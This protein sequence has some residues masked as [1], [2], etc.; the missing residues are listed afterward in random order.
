LQQK[1]IKVFWTTFS[2]FFLYIICHKLTENKNLDTKEFFLRNQSEAK[3]SKRYNLNSGAKLWYQIIRISWLRGHATHI[4]RHQ[5]LEKPSK[6][7][8]IRVW[9][10]DNLYLGTSS[11]GN[12]NPHPKN[13]NSWTRSIRMMQRSPSLFDKSF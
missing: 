7:G 8:L 10:K 6:S 5:I 2:F 4:Q 3:I 1:Q 13:I 9:F 11:I 12:R